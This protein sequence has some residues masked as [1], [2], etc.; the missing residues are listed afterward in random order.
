MEPVI[1]QFSLA[2]RCRPI[3]K[4]ER[5]VR[6][7]DSVVLNSRAAL[8]LLTLLVVPLASGCREEPS[9]HRVRRDPSLES[10]TEGQTKARTRAP[11]AIATH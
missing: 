4:E 3:F 2:S 8:F 6:S 1:R 5:L 7:R 11:R 9:S 10:Q